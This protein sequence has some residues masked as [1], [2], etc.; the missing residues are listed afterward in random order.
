VL[1]DV[2]LACVGELED[3]LALLVVQRDEPGLGLQAPP[4]RSA[5]SVMIS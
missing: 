3:A 4:L 1:L 2:G 5:I